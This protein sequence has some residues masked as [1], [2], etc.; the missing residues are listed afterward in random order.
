MVNEAAIVSLENFWNKTTSISNH[1]NMVIINRK[2]YG[3][4]FSNRS[5]GMARPERNEE[6]KKP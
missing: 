6:G 2:Y 4:V 3:F 1:K 5:G